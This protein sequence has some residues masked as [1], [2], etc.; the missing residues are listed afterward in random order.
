LLFSFIFLIF[1]TPV[2][3]GSNIMIIHDVTADPGDVITVEIEIM[4]DDL[5]YNF[6]LDIPIPEGFTYVNGS[7]A[8][9]PQR[10]N[11]H[12]ISANVRPDNSLRILSY[13]VGGNHFLGNDG[14]VASFSFETSDVPGS[15]PLNI[16][17]AAIGANFNNILTGTQDGTVYLAGDEPEQFT[18]EIE[19]DG[20]GTV[21]V[22]GIEYTEPLLLNAG[23]YHFISATPA[24]GWQFD[25]WS[26]D[27]IGNQSPVSVHMT[28][29]KSITANFSESS[30]TQYILELDIIGSGN[31]MVNGAEYTGPVSVSEGTTLNLL[32]EP[33]NGWQFD[34]WGGDATGTSPQL[35]VVMDNDKLITADFSLLPTGENS[36]I[37]N[38]ATG[39]VGQDTQM[40]IEI[41]NENEFVAFQADIIIPDGFSYVENSAVLNEDRIVDHQLE[42]NMISRGIL[43]LFAFSPDNNP[44]IGEQGPVVFFELANTGQTGTFPVNFDDGFIS[45]INS[46]DILTNMVSGSITIQVVGENSMIINDA[47][48]LIGNQTQMELEII[49]EDE[50]VGFQA[51]IVIPDGFTYVENSAEFN[52]ART[53]DH[54]LEA[55]IQPSGLLRIYAFSPENNPF[56][57]NNGPVVFFELQNNLLAGDYVIEI[58]EGII[59][60][61]NGLDIL[62]E[63]QNGT[64]TLFDVHT[65][66]YI[67]GSN[68]TVNGQPQV[69]QQVVNG[70]DG[71]EVEAIPDEG[72]YFVDW[73]DGLTDNPRT[74]IN[75]IDDLTVTAEFA[76]NTYT[77][78][79]TAGQGGSIFPAGEITVTHG[80]NQS[81]TITVSEGYEIADVLVDGESQGAIEEY[82]FTNVTENHTIEA[83]FE[84]KTYTITA[85]SG[86]GGTI[87]PSGEVIVQHGQD[88]SF[89][90]QPNEGYHILNVIVDDVSIGQIS[91]YTFIEVTMNRSIHAEFAINT[92]NIAASA[93]NA[94]FG[95]VTGGGEY[96]HFQTAELTA[97]PNTGYHFV[98]W[99][100]NGDVVMDGDAPAGA[101]YTFT[102]DGPRDL[103]ANF[104]INTY[105]ISATANNDDFGSVTGG[106]EYE[107]FATATLTASPETGYHFVNWTE[108]GVVVLDGDAP[109]G[110][111][112]TF[113]VDGPRDLVANFAIN[114]YI[115]SASAND[116]DFGSVTGAGEYAHF[117]TATL[118]ASPETGYLFVNW[119]ENGDEVMDGDAPAGATYTFT[120]DGPRDL[121]ANFAINTYIISVTANDEDFGSVTGSG[122]YNHFDT[123]TLTA[124]ANT[125]YHFVNWTE[126]GDVVMDRDAPAGATYTFTVDGPRDLVAHFAINTYII[127]VSANNDDFGSVTGGGE[128]N[129]FETATLTASP[130]IGYHFVNWTENGDVV[131]DGDAPAGATY[132]FTV[133]GPRDLVAV[134]AINNYIIYVSANNDDFGSV[135]GGG[136]YDHF[137]MTELIANPAIGYHFVNWTENGVEVSDESIYTFAVTGPRDLVANFAI[138]TYIITAT[139]NNDDFGSV[140]GGG[141]YNH[142]E[143]ATLTASPETGYH[144]VDWT[145]NGDE[146][147]D[148]DAPANATYTF[149]VDG[150]RDLIANF[151]INVYTLLYIAGPNGTIDGELQVEQQVEH[152]SNSEEVT[153]IPNEGYHFVQW[154]D[155]VTDNPRTDVDVTGPITVTASFEAID[156]NLTL[157]VEPEGAGQVSITAQQEDYNI[158]DEIE[159]TATANDGYL[160]Q[161]WRKDNSA[162]SESASFTY[163]MPAGNV[164][165][166][167]HFVEEEAILY[168]ISLEV[169]PEDGG[170]VIGDGQ[171]E[172]G[173][174]IAVQAI[175]NEGYHFV[176]W[177]EG[178]TIVSY[179]PA[180][181]FSVQDNRHLVASFDMNRYNLTLETKPQGF[182]GGSV[183]GE[184]NYT[185]GTEVTVSARSNIDY[186]FTHWSE[187]GAVVSTEEHFTFIIESDRHLVATF[188]GS[189]WLITTDVSPEEAGTVSGGGEY[190]QNE[191]VTL[192]ATEEPGY[193]FLRWMDA[194]LGQVSLQNPYLF[195]AT[196]DRHIT[197]EFFPMF[198]MLP[199][200]NKENQVH[201]TASV[202]PQ[203]SGLIF[204]DGFHP[205]NGEGFYE[206]GQ[207]VSL[208]ASPNFGINFIHWMLD[209][210]IVETELT[211]TFTATEDIDLVAV[212]GGETFTVTVTAN[213]EEGG[214]ASVS[215]NG[216]FFYG[217]YAQLTATPNPGWQFA[218]WTQDNDQQVSTNPNHGFTVTEDRELTANFEPITTYNLVLMADPEGAGELSGAGSYAHGEEATIIA[219]QNP[220]YTFTFWGDGPGIFSLQPDTTFIMTEEKEL[221]AY[222]DLNSYTISAVSSN[223]AFGSV[224]GAG[225]YNHFE[226]AT[227]T[228]TPETGYHCG[229]GRR[230]TRRSYL[231][232][233]SG[234][235]A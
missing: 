80:A 141:E 57:G 1:V 49:N 178:N 121:V 103:V 198:K 144:F 45:D 96:N 111:T 222:F 134:F 91:E 110:A 158:G 100:E 79:A 151:A 125:G 126:N 120:V 136:T 105:I 29:N 39:L 138:N 102:V 8:L 235:P 152:G 162:I 55:G 179:N 2:L 231:Y 227:L 88:K 90:I 119:T 168:A 163:V 123:A 228:A 62:S 11:G 205:I 137:Q 164:T 74:D 167:A 106:G 226:T 170:T 7:A 104:A 81:F 142:F 171:F 92:H 52:D 38:D 189:D 191:T 37:I 127:S 204:G 215:N 70:S 83:Q 73:S 85:T 64:I 86:E 234:W 60:S 41:I 43:R 17:N 3:A 95:T 34:A 157:A 65:L 192:L 195:S 116:D 42:A 23:S 28:S 40:E 225:E 115:I 66:L 190:N 12:T 107:H 172:E 202:F 46:V 84:L 13:H 99:T 72:Y 130:A 75:V 30:T 18:L 233:Y 33:D 174:T 93:N 139:P 155:E 9:N 20:Q 135:A 214:E 156:Y 44:F 208:T 176:S 150:P 26:G 97:I 143:T 124:T 98:N 146:V 19:I 94:D 51:D 200:S 186:S 132:T 206:A 117:E 22:S 224:T 68:G 109:A 61:A 25:G 211:H 5:F 166:T 54:Q 165:L 221:T 140:S 209:D 129:H 32:A 67:A 220:G 147:M 217:E 21:M 47:T 216:Q 196:A 87:N 108:D 128:Y 210:E 203:G 24:T 177:R 181:S 232:L 35:E 15:Y 113:T 219:E 161:N 78:T 6:N 89:S 148:G 182:A 71:D 183:W 77:I 159:V 118:T 223:E 53:D 173:E 201:I 230:S 69:E 184:G 63:T 133:D 76:I 197:A 31:V 149:T 131:M 114:T 59:S 16:M 145:E 175:P 187:D 160:F 112:Y 212:F 213:P 82:A 207:E 194:E 180:Y 58:Y 153:A 50:F 48:G 229:D 101:T 36:M 199:M 27:F 56:A 122:E 218:N 10:S 193:L 4:N 154:S 185:H 188:S 14:I 169:L